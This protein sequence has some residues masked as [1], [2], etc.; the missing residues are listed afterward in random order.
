MHWSKEM[1]I[2]IFPW[3]L[4]M[5][6]FT[7]LPCRAITGIADCAGDNFIKKGFFVNF[8]YRKYLSTNW[9]SKNI[10][11]LLW[12]VAHPISHRTN[13]KK[14]SW[15]TLIGTTTLTVHQW[16]FTSTQRGS[17]TRKIVEHSVNS[18]PRWWK[19]QTSTLSQLGKWFSGCETPHLKVRYV[20]QYY[21]LNID[22]R[23]ENSNSFK[24][25]S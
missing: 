22:F 16:V 14:Y 6:F 5:D 17:K 18:W 13:W 2:K 15:P 4:G 20:Y 21:V 3:N 19:D 12:T 25:A 9:Y 7:F 24:I 1:S 23:R 8:F 11:V 10:I